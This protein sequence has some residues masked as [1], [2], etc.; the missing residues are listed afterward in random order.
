MPV[1]SNAN[2]HMRVVTICNFG[3]MDSVTLSSY[4]KLNLGL[5]ITGPRRDGYHNIRSLFQEVDLA[6]TLSFE[7]LDEDRVEIACPTP[8]VPTDGRNLTSRAAKL[9]KIEFKVTHG[10]RIGIQKRIPV[11][12]GMGGGS[13][14]AATTLIALQRLWGLR[15]DDRHLQAMALSLG[16]DVPFFLTGGASLVSGRGERIEPVAGIAEVSFVA[17]DPGF[18][19]STSW[20]FANVEFALTEGTRYISFLNSV[21]ASGRVDAQGLFRCSTNDFLPV[22]LAKFPAA[23]AVIRQLAEAGSL[24]SDVTGSGSVFFGCFRDPDAAVSAA[25][26]LRSAGYRAWPCQPRSLVGCCRVV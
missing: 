2:P 24:Y 21:K 19:V 22:V 25:S 4:A 1:N 3:S 11:G 5:K 15:V 7:C 26:R 17:V 14:N 9:L 10:V 13:A 18:S 20:A 23:K 8:G 6:D 12:G 16:S